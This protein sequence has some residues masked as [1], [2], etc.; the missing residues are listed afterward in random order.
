MSMNYNTYSLDSVCAAYAYICGFDAPE[1]AAAAN[2]TLTAFA[3]NALDGKKADRLFIY[4]PD[5]I[6]QW[7]DDKYRQLIPEVLKYGTLPLPLKTVMPSVTPVCFATMYTGVQPDVHGIQRYEKPV[8]RIK[9]LFDAAIKAG[10]KCAIVAESNCSIAKIFLEREMDYYILDTIPEVN[11]KAAELIIA[12]KY[13][14]ICV[15]NGNY[16][17][18]MHKY[19]PE[20]IEALAELRQNSDAFGTFVN[21]IK[22]NW[23]QH[24]TFYGFAMDHGCHEIDGKCGSHGLDMPE[25]LNIRHYYGAVKAEA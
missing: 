15:Y 7:I 17:T 25:D 23:K 3:D 8:L 1:Q 6:A 22:S 11:A 19:S 24:N 9:T 14:I 20:G 5:A 10:K 12:D 16:D 4:N 18:L 13:D 2:G 21:L